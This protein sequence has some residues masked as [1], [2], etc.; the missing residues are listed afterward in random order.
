M[1]SVACVAPAISADGPPATNEEMI[2]SATGEAL[3]KMLSEYDDA[4][5]EQPALVYLNMD[6]P[7]GVRTRIT[8]L[9]M[10]HG[11]RVAA[12][13][14]DVATIRI[15][16]ETSHRLLKR[17]GKPHQRELHTRAFFS[18]MSAENEIAAATE[19]VFTHSDELSKADVEHVQGNWPHSRFHQ[20]EE[21]K[22]RSL[23]KKMAEPVLIIGAA[24]TTIYL[25][26]NVRS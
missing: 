12:T 17:S 19:A 8:A 18:L 20:T 24:A 16:W 26:Y 21:S 10:D 3:I 2:A 1:L 6:A 5:K 13:G 7:A 23:I 9:L 15:E 4:L 14:E 22:R 25:L 11:V